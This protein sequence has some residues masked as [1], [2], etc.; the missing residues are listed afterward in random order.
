MRPAICNAGRPSPC[1]CIGRNE[2][3]P[4]RD[5]CGGVI[6]HPE[7]RDRS[8]EPKRVA[9]I[10]RRIGIAGDDI[11]DDAEIAVEMIENF[12]EAVPLRPGVGIWQ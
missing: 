3:C 2:R 6:R 1:N 5:P 4:G 10:Y 11:V 12:A 7:I 8:G 9:G